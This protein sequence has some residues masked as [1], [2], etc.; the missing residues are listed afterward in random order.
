MGNG[1]RFLRPGTDRTRCGR[2][3]WRMRVVAVEIDESI[4]MLRILW[5]FQ[6]F[7]VSYRGFSERRGR[8]RTKKVRIS[9][10]VRAVQRCLVWSG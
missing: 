7:F 3:W 6:V 8:R 5:G 1:R 10:L 4:A 2:V 9:Y